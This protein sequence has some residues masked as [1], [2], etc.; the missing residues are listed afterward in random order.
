VISLHTPSQSAKICVICGQSTAN[1]FREK[2]F[3]A[4]GERGEVLGHG[5]VVAQHEKV[6]ALIAKLFIVEPDK[7]ILHE[8][9]TVGKG[10]LFG[11]AQAFGFKDKHLADGAVDISEE[12]EEV[13]LA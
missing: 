10:G 2:C 5:N 12:D 7:I 13:S 6:K 4:S 11:E 3:D 9:A 1:I 8:G